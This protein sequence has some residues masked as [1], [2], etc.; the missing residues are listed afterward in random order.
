MLLLVGDHIV[1]LDHVVF[2]GRIYPAGLALP[3]VIARLAFGGDALPI[4]KS[5]GRTFYASP[6]PA[7]SDADGGNHPAAAGAG[8]GGQ[9]SEAPQPGWFGGWWK[10]T[11]T[12]TGPDAS[13]AAQAAQ[14]VETKPA[15]AAEGAPA[16]LPKAPKYM[17]SL[18]P[19]AEALD[20]LNLKDGTNTIV[21]CCAGGFEV[22]AR[23]YLWQVST[24]I[25]ISDIDGTITK[26]DKL[27]HMYTFIGKDWSHAGVASLYK[28]VA[29]NGYNMLYLSSRAIGMAT[30]TRNYIDSLAQEGGVTL[31]QGPVIMSPDRLFQSLHREIVI[32][33]YNHPFSTQVL[34][35]LK[36]F[37]S[38]TATL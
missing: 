4:D 25:V 8:G 30:Q 31:P 33:R 34:G 24:K 29:D 36:M 35:L 5:C 3:F 2:A 13:A 14:A 28:A 23:I 10:R 19:S 16:K 6:R 21:F 27:G 20:S 1:H 22:T 26:S 17:K 15:K 32:H 9:G 38:T 18:K 12:P 37:G 11:E 7:I